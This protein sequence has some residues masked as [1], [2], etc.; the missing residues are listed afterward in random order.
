MEKRVSKVS[1]ARH[2]SSTLTTGGGRERY[3]C[4][5]AHNSLHV[6]PACATE[7]A[8]K[9]ARQHWRAFSFSSCVE[10]RIGQSARLCDTRGINRAVCPFA[11]CQVFPGSGSLSRQ[12]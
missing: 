12:C 10:D 7:H 11:A 2:I 6:S 9:N 5:I 3:E 8:S 1:R 4:S